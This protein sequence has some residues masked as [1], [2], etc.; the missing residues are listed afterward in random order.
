VTRQIR[1]ELLKLRTTRTTLGLVLG[2]VALVVFTVVIQLVAS[3]FEDSGIPRIEESDTQRTVFATASTAGLFAVLIG[4][5]SVT[6]EFR[7]GTIRPTLL[8][9]PARAALVAAK[10]AACALAGVVLAVAAVVLTFGI[11][12]TWLQI[13]EVA[14]SLGRSDLAAI[15]AGTVAATVWWA[16]IGVGVGAVIRNQV[17][18]ILGTILWAS[19]PEPLLMALVP[20]LG[21]FAPGVAADAVAGAP[22]GRMLS[23]LASGLVLTLWAL[24]IV[25]AGAVVT[26]RRDVP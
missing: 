26:A 14:Q 10:C 22:D 2:M 24:V 1:S 9:A 8:F 5:M 3:Q 15:A 4:I 25:V 19:I 17:A 18:A 12:W 23:P 6:G 13:D 20:D 7:H 11:A 16:V 21:R